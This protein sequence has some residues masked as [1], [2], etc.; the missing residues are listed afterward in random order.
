VLLGYHLSRIQRNRGAGKPGRHPSPCVKGAGCRQWHR[1]SS[2]REEAIGA[3]TDTFIPT[4]RDRMDAPRLGALDAPGIV[5]GSSALHAA[6]R[7]SGLSL[8]V[9]MMLAVAALAMALATDS[10]ALAAFGFESLLDAAASAVLVW[11]FRV[12][13]R[14]SGQGER[15]EEIARRVLAMVLLVVS[16]YLIIVSI[17]SLFAGPRPHAS[18]ESIVLAAL[19]VVVLPFIAFRKRQLARR[20]NSRA[21]RADGLLTAVAAALAATTLAA[22]L[23]NHYFG[24]AV[25]DPIAALIAAVVL[26]Q[27]AVAAPEG[28]D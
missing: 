3:G 17:H 18:T 9:G 19:S 8:V 26:A 21:L 2:R 1:G 27:E 14:D 5:N 11:R 4:W 6:I 7:I 12:H 10:L 28:L 15:I 20:L 13:R 23:L 24:L 25:A 16:F 22:M